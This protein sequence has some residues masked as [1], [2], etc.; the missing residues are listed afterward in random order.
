[1]LLAV[2]R[3]ARKLC[4]SVDPLALDNAIVARIQVWSA[5]IDYLLLFLDESTGPELEAT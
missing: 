5:L 2:I 1:M 3:H 4:D